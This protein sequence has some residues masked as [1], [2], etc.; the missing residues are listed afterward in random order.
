WFWLSP[1]RN[2]PFLIWGGLSP[3]RNSSFLIWFWLSPMRNSPFLIWGGLSPMRNSLFLIWFWLSP[4]RNS[5]FLIWGELPPMR[6]SSLLIGVCL[7]QIRKSP[8]PHSGLA[9]A[10]Q[11]KPVFHRK[12]Q[13][14]TRRVESPG[15]TLYGEKGDA[16]PNFL[17]IA[18]PNAVFI[19]TLAVLYG[20]ICAQQI[21]SRRLEDHHRPDSDL[22]HIPFI[23]GGHN[24][25]S[26]FP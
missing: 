3:M 24:R 10:N 2:S 6:N 21:V 1:M 15:Q 25:P 22:D 14:P 11:A 18:F 4:M 20:Y 19:G 26:Q 16:K 5:P 12:L 8:I 9:S 13:T 23:P 17:Q 7:P